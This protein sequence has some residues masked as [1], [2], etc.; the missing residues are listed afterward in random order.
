M[1]T[2]TKKTPS[3]SLD[4]FRGVDLCSHHT[5]PRCAQDIRNFRILPDGSLKKRY[6][7]RPIKSFTS[8]KKNA[9][10]IGSRN[11]K[12]LAYFL[13][14]LSVICLNLQTYEEQVIG[15][16]S[17]SCSNAFFF[18]YEGNLYLCHDQ[19]ISLIDDEGI[20][21]AEGYVPLIGKDWNN[22]EPG[23]DYEPKNILTKRARISYIISDPASI[24]LEVK[25][26]IA[27]VDGVIVNGIP[28]SSQDYYLDT[29]LGTVNV[30][31]LNAGDRVMIY[32]TLDI[33]DFAQLDL[34]KNACEAISF[35]KNTDN[36][37]FF[38]DKNGSS[39]ML[40]SSYVTQESRKE[41]QQIYPNS[42]SL[43]IPESPPFV[44]G[45]RNSSIRSA[46]HHYD[47]LLLFTEEDA[48]MARAEVSSDDEFP[49]VN[50][51]STVGCCSQHG[52][53]T[54]G[55]ELF[56]VCQQ[57]VWQWSGNSEFSGEMH[58]V[59]ISTPIDS[60]LVDEDFSKC[61][62]YYNGRER[63][64]WLHFPS[65][66]YV[67]IYQLDLKQWYRFDVSAD[68]FFEANG[69]FGFCASTRVFVFDPT[70]F[71]DQ[72]NE[73]STSP[74]RAKYLSSYSDFGTKDPKII[75][76]ILLVGDFETNQIDIFAKDEKKNYAQIQIQEPKGYSLIRNRTS[77]RS[78]FPYAALYVSVYDSN[79]ITIYR[80]ELIAR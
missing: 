75:K 38:L 47:H 74:I 72:P 78:R 56:T 8:T 29:K 71:Y 12:P 63:E 26:K 34:L 10:W 3:F 20:H 68:F 45:N 25:D 62:L 53:V 27:S 61:G 17:R 69:I 4:G 44:L 31:N 46:Q 14:N 43:Y 11:S 50:I 7:Y 39:S 37:L 18:F 48:W 5:D 6:G 60:L 73:S 64:L 80:A 23:P 67:W 58:T 13:T 30:Q 36:R 28:I 33:E 79:P 57:G 19:N 35:G 77:S 22:R 40:C 70:L 76:E 51:N 15:S 59:R 54:V 65:R 55:N 9:Y 32:V 1:S 66:S 49:T 16:L 2:Q 52:S 42:D 21:P 24:F 41:A